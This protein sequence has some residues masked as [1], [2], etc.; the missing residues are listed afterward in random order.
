MHQFS[1]SPFLKNES[2]NVDFVENNGI[3]C[4]YFFLSH[5]FSYIYFVFITISEWK[6]IIVNFSFLTTATAKYS[7]NEIHVYIKINEYGLLI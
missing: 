4:D 7:I 1:E 3:G 2:N 5:S 6:I